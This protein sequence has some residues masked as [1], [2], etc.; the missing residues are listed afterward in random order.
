MIQE[1]YLFLIFIPCRLEKEY[2]FRKEKQA[3]ENSECI[4]SVCLCS[5][6]ELLELG[7]I[8]AS[9]SLS[10]FPSPMREQS[11]T[12][13]F[14]VQAAVPQLHPFQL[15]APRS[16]PLQLLLPNCVRFSLSY[17]SQN[18]SASCSYCSPIMSNSA[19]APRLRRLLL[20]LP[21]HVR[22]MSG[23]TRFSYCSPVV[24]TC[25]RHSGQFQPVQ[26]SQSFCTEFEVQRL[27]LSTKVVR[28]YS[29][30]PYPNIPLSLVTHMDTRFKS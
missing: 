23:C 29:L 2:L 18:A 10:Y 22:F 9:S 26:Y 13:Q 28:H 12:R 14:S 21:D 5:W 6:T 19:A 27:Q 17:C 24:S 30:V 16:C 4:V 25:S 15:A 7:V 3:M 1:Q 20:L 8:C 11:D